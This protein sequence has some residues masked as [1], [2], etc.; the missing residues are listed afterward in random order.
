MAIIDSSI[1]INRP[2]EEVFAFLCNL[3]N[4]KL[5]SPTFT[6]VTLHGPFAVGSRYTLSGAIMGRNF[7]VE[8]E[9]AAI[10][11]NKKLAIKTLAPPPASPVTNTYNFE[12]SAGGTLLTTTMD[13]V[14]F[15]GTEG[16]VKPQLKGALDTAN[17]VLKKLLEG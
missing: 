8:N 9:I 10:E 12:P 13:A 15:P 1:Q 3:E 7:S 14:I 17:A 11:P 6:S 4:Q 2:V 16:M 5:M